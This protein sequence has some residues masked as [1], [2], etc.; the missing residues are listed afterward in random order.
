MP[1]SMEMLTNSSILGSQP[2]PFFE[3]LLSSYLEYCSLLQ[4]KFLQS[5]RF[6]LLFT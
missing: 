6:K 5:V 3:D 2:N 1:V 4:S